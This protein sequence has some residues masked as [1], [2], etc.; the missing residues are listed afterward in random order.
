MIYK[1]LHA[2]AAGMWLFVA[3][4]FLGYLNSYAGKIPAVPGSRIDSLINKIMKDNYV[5]GLSIAIING[6]QQQIKTYGYSN[7]ESNT[8]VTPQTLF[9]IGSCSKAFTALAMIKLANEQHINLDQP[10][11]K[12]LPW[13]KATYKKAL[14]PVTL[15]QLLNHTS[16]IPW[17][18]IST[19]PQRNDA[20]ALAQTVRNV[21]SIQLHNLPGTQYEY[22]TINY[23]IIALVIQIITGKPFESYIQQYVLDGLQLG[24]TSIGVPVNNAGIAQGYKVSFL[25]ARAYNSPLFKGNNAAGYV[26]SNATDMV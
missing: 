20:G 22:A 6:G 11:S 12:Y 17:K 4:I 23:D 2:P 3:F 21:A 25:N 1:K 9:Q 8:R 24:Q 7:L 16:G 5:P 13:F 14:V 18:T 26:I 10:V 19:I 15:R